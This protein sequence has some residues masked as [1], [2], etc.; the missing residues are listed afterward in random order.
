[1]ATKAAIS[2]FSDTMVEAISVCEKCPPASIVRCTRNGGGCGGW[3]A[4]LAPFPGLGSNL[5]GFWSKFWTFVPL[6]SNHLKQ[7][8][9]SLGNGLSESPWQSLSSESSPSPPLPYPPGKKLHKIL[10]FRMAARPRRWEAPFFGTWASGGSPVSWS[11]F[12]VGEES[13]IESVIKLVP[14]LKIKSTNQGLFYITSWIDL[15][16][17]GH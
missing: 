1:M 14:Q 11:W 6:S 4:K 10:T 15:P 13:G 17:A 7:L 12:M 9:V 5:D 2:P 3:G 8:V 16:L